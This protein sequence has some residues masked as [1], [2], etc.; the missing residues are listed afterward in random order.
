MNSRCVFTNTLPT[1]PYRGAGRPEASY[2]M[3]RI[4]DA[5]AAQTGIDG[6]ELRRRNL[7]APDKIPYVTP[8]G[9]TYD[10]GDFTGAFERA[11][12]RADY[13]GFAARKKAAKKR[14]KLRGF[15]VGCYLEIAGGF[16]EESA[17]I[18]F[19]GGDKVSVS[20]GAGG[21]GQG[22]PTVFPKVAARRLGIDPAAVTLSSATARATSPAWAPS[23]RARR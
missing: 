1:G 9:N 5:A 19:P 2:L 16:P 22:H 21:S 4:I 10:S 17:R 7:I 11:L 15:G 20:V 3:E 14:G 12:T 23:P 18:A 13:A 6:V 8:F